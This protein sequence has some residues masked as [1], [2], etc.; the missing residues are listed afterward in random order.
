MYATINGAT[1]LK[2]AH[3]YVT[4]VYTYVCMPIVDTG[5]RNKNI[6]EL[7]FENN[8]PQILLC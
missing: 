4:Y 2:H 1:N 3:A 6:Q 5:P 7:P 8:K